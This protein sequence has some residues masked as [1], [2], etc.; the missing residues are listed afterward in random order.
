VEKKS[1]GAGLLDSKSKARVERVTDEVNIVLELDVFTDKHQ[2]SDVSTPLPFLN[3]L[4]ETFARHSGFSFYVKAD[5]DVDVDDHHLVEEVGRCLG[6]ALLQA[7]AGKGLRFG[8]AIVPM[9]DS[10]ALCAVDFS[11]R[12][13]FIWDARFLDNGKIGGVTKENI[14]HLFCS[15]AAEGRFNLSF[16]IKGDNDHHK[17]EAAM[18]AFAVAMR[19]LKTGV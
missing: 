12:P 7:F 10:L 11:G 6:Q 5:G 1:L 9:D 4:L 18:K 2:G 19:R 13:C 3:H 15:I 8:D 14:D 17:A 16:I